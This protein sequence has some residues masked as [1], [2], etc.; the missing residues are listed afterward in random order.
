MSERVHSIISVF[1]YSW[2]VFSAV[3]EDLCFTADGVIV[4]RIFRTSGKYAMLGWDNIRKKEEKLAE[5]SIE[6]LLKANKNNFV[7]PNSKIKKVELKKYLRLARINIMT[8]EKKYGWF[9][10]GIPS[11]KSSKIEDYERILRSVFP[12]KLSVPK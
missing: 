6:E 2:F 3:L 9:V 5:L 4:A 10:R 8:N 11:E 7:I 1:R 12:Y